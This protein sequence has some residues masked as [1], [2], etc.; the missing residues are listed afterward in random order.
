MPE[1]AVY[2]LEPEENRLLFG[3]CE[4]GMAPEGKIRLLRLRVSEGKSGNIKAGK[5]RECRAFPDLL[6]RQYE[7]TS[8]GRDNETV[9]ECFERLRRDLKQINRGVTASDYEELVRR[10]P[11]F[12][13]LQHINCI[14]RHTIVKIRHLPVRVKPFIL[15]IADHPDAL[16]YQQHVSGR[17]RTDRALFRAGRRMD[18]CP[19]YP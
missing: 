19:D 2:V 10:T 16:Y 12:S 13:R 9:E 6:V 8:G 1:D 14:L 17:K 5:I 15:P 7:S 18:S 3:N 11:F 4:K